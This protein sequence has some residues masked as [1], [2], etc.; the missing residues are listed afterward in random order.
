[1][2]TPNTVR[3]NRVML[4]ALAAALLAIPATNAFAQQ[5]GSPRAEGFAEQRRPGQRGPMG[6][7]GA[8]ALGRFFYSPMQVLREAAE[9]GLTE[10]QE[11][12]VQELMDSHQASFRQLQFQ[13]GN[14][15]TRMAALAVGE[16]VSL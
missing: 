16:N 2:R 7:G 10:E 5:P 6:E 9:I 14:E 3:R 8:Q 12:A 13:L 4:A 11:Q 15:M 1:M